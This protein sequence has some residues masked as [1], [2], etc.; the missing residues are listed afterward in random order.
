MKNYTQNV[1]SVEAY[2]RNTSTDGD[3]YQRGL[4]AAYDVTI[5][6][7][8]LYASGSVG[9]MA[10][11]NITISGGTVNAIG[12]AEQDS[13]STGIV[14]GGNNTGGK[15]TISGGTV[16]AS[17]NGGG[18]GQGPGIGRRTAACG[19]II[20]SGGDVTVS[21]TARSG[22]DGGAAAIG[23]G[24]MATAVGCNIT[25]TSGITRLVVTKGASAQDHIGR[26]NASSSVGTITIDGINNPT[27]VPLL[28]NL[29]VAVSNDGNT[30]TFTPRSTPLE[31]V[32]TLSD[33]KDLINDVYG[34]QLYLGR[35]VY[36]NGTIGTV[37]TDAVGR[38]AHVSPNASTDAGSVVGS[39]ILVLALTDLATNV[40]VAGANAAITGTPVI[41]GASQTA[42]KIPTYWEWVDM[43]KSLGAG[44]FQT[45]IE[46]VGMD[47]STHYWTSRGVNGGYG[48]YYVY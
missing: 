26:G 28:P 15:L 11:R 48:R 31:M 47:T 39:R 14:P 36:S 34:C 45:L 25:I 13:G 27:A 7:G 21:S 5:T 38:I 17:G 1:G 42:W 12:K 33:L 22:F 30:L 29:D 44:N 3:A 6:G 43:G 32:G 16:V 4:D 37:A 19:D 10:G 24:S 20:I 46:S 40:D 41:G 18:D 8:T 35:Y 23:A 2:G 9:I